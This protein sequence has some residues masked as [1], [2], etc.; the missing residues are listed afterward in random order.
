MVKVRI[1][2][3]DGI[4]DFASCPTV[5]AAAEHIIREHRMV[6][7]EDDYPEDIRI[8]KATIEEES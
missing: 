6:G 8:I 7:T 4:K 5:V 2:W 1:T 3:S